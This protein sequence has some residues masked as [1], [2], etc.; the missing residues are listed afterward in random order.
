MLCRWGRETQSGNV[1]KSRANV[2]ATMK[3]GALI[4]FMP[5]F[6]GLV[7]NIDNAHDC[8]LT[9]SRTSTPACK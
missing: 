2:H 1:I 6:A 5:L 9:A 4:I 3:K 7:K 8:F